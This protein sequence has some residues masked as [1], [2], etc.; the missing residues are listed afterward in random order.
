MYIH[1]YGLKGR[2]L[3]YSDQLQTILM[4]DTMKSRL[5]ESQHV[6]YYKY[7]HMIDDKHR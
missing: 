1:P 4:Y 7:K 6:K 2:M 3:E 5:L